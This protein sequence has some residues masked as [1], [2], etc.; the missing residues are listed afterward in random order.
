MLKFLL[1]TSKKFMALERAADAD[2]RGKRASTRESTATR[3]R[4]ELKSL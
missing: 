3:L 4:P 2:V 1:P